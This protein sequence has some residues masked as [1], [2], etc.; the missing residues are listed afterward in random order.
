LPWTSN[1]SRHR[2]GLTSKKRATYLL[3]VN[4]QP[5]FSSLQ[6]RDLPPARPIGSVATA[7]LHAAETAQSPKRQIHPKPPQTAFQRPKSQISTRQGIELYRSRSQFRLSG[8]WLASW[9][10]WT[11][12]WRAGGTVGAVEPTRMYS[13]CVSRWPVPDPRQALGSEDKRQSPSGI[14]LRAPAASVQP[15]PRRPQPSPSGHKPKEPSAFGKSVPADTW[16]CRS[17]A[18]T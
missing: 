9:L 2:A 7:E 13:H 12:H 11:A 4:D 6:K 5:P 3:C 17:R 16:P 1:H 14:R 8:R 18:I 10:G 15:T